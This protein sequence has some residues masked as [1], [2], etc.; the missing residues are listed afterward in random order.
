M[1]LWHVIWHVFCPSLL[2]LRNQL[3]VLFFWRYCL[4]L[5]LRV[6]SLPLVFG[7]ANVMCPD[8]VFFG[9]TLLGIGG[10][11][12][13]GS[14]MSRL[15]LTLDLENSWSLSLHSSLWLHFLSLLKLYLFVMSY[16]S[17]RLFCVLHSF[18]LFLL[19]SIFSSDL[20]SSILI[21]SS[22]LSNLLLY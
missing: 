2:L 6:L 11:S 13:F 16:M 18:Q 20:Y 10:V 4:W 9:S 17:L 19:L 21:L 14:T 7:C 1:V 22:A 15:D 12:L 5:L 3:Y 8:M